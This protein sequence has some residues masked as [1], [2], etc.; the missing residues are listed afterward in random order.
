M[1][2]G[3]V[4]AVTLSICWGLFAVVWLI[5]AA[6]NARRAPTV[7]RRNPRMPSIL[8]GVIV[9]W[10]LLL[11]LPQGGW[12]WLRVGGSWIRILGLVVVVPSTAFT[13][14][15]RATLGTMW[16]SWATAKQGHLLRQDGPYAITRHPIYT[17][18][19]GMLSG[20]ALT[21]GLGRWVLIV[22]GGV[23]IAELKIRSEERL[24]TEVFPDEYERYRH[25]VPRLIPALRRRAR[26]S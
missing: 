11:L 25:K 15:A 19:L 3:Q 20:T 13:L 23:V 5:G 21:A 17:G 7:Q 22:A 8:G 16:S 6:Y 9:I 1:T 10:L 14:W 18:M 24:L 2:T 12:S 4:V 26:V